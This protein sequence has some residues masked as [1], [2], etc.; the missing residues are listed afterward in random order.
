MNETVDQKTADAQLALYCGMDRDRAHDFINAANGRKIHGAAMGAMKQQG[1]FNADNSLTTVGCAVFDLVSKIW[2]GEYEPAPAM[3]PLDL[4]YGVDTTRAARLET[5]KNGY[6]PRVCSAHLKALRAV[7]RNPGVCIGNLVTV[8]GYRTLEELKMAK[9]I[10]YPPLTAGQKFFPVLPTQVA[11]N[12]FEW[13]AKA[14]GIET[15]D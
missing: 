5:V 9:L 2:D 12:L 15:G 10:T 6:A 3:L 7:L 11:K 8:Y 13:I 1:L 14:Q 4:L